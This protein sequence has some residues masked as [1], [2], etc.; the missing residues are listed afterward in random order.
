[1][2]T[3]TDWIS[4]LAI[5]AAGLILGAMV[6][7]T[8]RR[9]KAS[10]ATKRVEL[11]TRR[12]ALVQQLRDLGTDAADEERT[13]LESETAE[14]LQALDRLPAAAATEETPMRPRNATASFA[15]GVLCTLIVVGVGYYASTFMRD[16]G[17]VEAQIT[18]AKDAFARND[19]VSAF[20][21][22]NAVLENNPDE[23]RALTYN[24]VV[25]LSMGET[26][27]AVSM[28][29]RATERDPKLLDAW[30]ALAQARLHAGKKQEAAAAIEAAIKQ[31]PEEEQRIREVFS[32]M[33]GGKSTETAELPPGHPPL[34]GHDGMGTGMNPG[35]GM[36]TMPPVSDSTAAPSNPI[37]ITVSL[38]PSTTSRGGTLYVIARGGE[39]GH[40]IAVRRIETNA[41][42]VTIDFSSADSMMGGALPEKVHLEARLDADGDAGTTDLGDLRASANNVK[43]GATIAMTLAKAN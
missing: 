27:K 31:H 37:H 36:N 30:V 8:A 33:Q 24:A 23:P 35:K 40:P 12:D 9:R 28:L 6:Y 15:W 13:W 39:A 3:S 43:A 38:D 19:L 11:E 10:A 29:Q 25:R 21:Q 42:P 2:N 22:T 41:F 7:F 1:M 20:E 26:D 34:P 4:A 16:K 17:N 18:S 14:V 5:L 32:T